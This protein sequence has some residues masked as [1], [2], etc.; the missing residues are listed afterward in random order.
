MSQSVSR[1][2]PTLLRAGVKI[3][4]V[5]RQPDTR[6]WFILN[7]G[8]AAVLVED[9]NEDV[10]AWCTVSTDGEFEDVCITPNTESDDVRFIVKRNIGGVDLRYRERLAYDTE[11]EGGSSNRMA[12]SYVVKTIAGTAVVSGLD[13]LEGKTVVVWQGSSPLMTAGSG[14]TPAYPSTFTVSGGIITLPATFTGDV[15]VGLAYEGRWQSTKL[16]YAAQ[17]GTALSQRK[18]IHTVAPLLY[19]THNMA[20]LFGQNFDKMDPMPRMIGGV[21]QGTNT[22][23]ASHDYD[24]FTLPGVWSN[25]ARICM[26]MRAPLPAT[27]L[28][29]GMLIESNERG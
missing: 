20:I 2:N 11:A 13:H 27:V 18:I 15:V 12:D 29:I 16:A 6:I 26:K 9:P 28:G 3:V 22:L 1:Y 24:A 17:T 10:L 19:Q 5:Q 23:L 21:D 4:A 14:T 8:T 25:D 7:D